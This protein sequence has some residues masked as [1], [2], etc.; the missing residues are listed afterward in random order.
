MNNVWKKQM[1][2]V[3]NLTELLSQLVSD[4]FCSELPGL[5]S[6]K[7]KNHLHATMKV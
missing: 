7:S 3:W 2:I 6:F 5:D 1:G 4:F